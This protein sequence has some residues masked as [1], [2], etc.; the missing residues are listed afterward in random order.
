MQAGCSG[1]RWEGEGGL[2]LGS[3]VEGSLHACGFRAQGLGGRGEG[4]L[5][6]C[7]YVA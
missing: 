5:H 1:S 6:A 2:R 7:T 4:S 3:R